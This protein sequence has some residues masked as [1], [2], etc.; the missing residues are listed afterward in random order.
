MANDFNKTPPSDYDEDT[1][2]KK[3][4]PVYILI[5]VGIF[6]LALLLYMFADIKPS[7]KEAPPDHPNPQSQPATMN[8]TT[9][10]QSEAGRS[11][12]LDQPANLSGVTGTTEATAEDTAGGMDVGVATDSEGSSRGAGQ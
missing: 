9:P 6:L 10:V 4:I 2:Q 8:N 7:P 3:R 11:Q 1:R 12:D 5:L